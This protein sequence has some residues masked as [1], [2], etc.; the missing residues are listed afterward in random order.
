MPPTEDTAVP[1]FGTI[2]LLNCWLLFRSVETHW[3]SL[4]K[5]QCSRSSHRKYPTTWRYCWHSVSVF[6]SKPQV[7]NF[8]EVVPPAKTLTYVLI[9]GGSTVRLL[10][11]NQSTGWYQWHQNHPL[12]CFC[13]FTLCISLIYVG[14]IRSLFHVVMLIMAGDSAAK[15]LKKLLPAIASKTEIFRQMDGLGKTLYD[16]ATDIGEY[17]KKRLVWRL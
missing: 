6:N 5:L 9:A 10:T 17:L 1:S 3:T 7:N 8:F 16:Y 13:F 14:T 11:I 2:D 15:D 4:P 12:V